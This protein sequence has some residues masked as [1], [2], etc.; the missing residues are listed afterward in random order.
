MIARRDF[1]TLLGGAAAAWP[2]AARGQQTLPMVAFVNGGESA[3]TRSAEF[4][5]GLK[6]AGYLEGQNVTVEYHWINGQYDRLPALMIDLVRRR[7]RVIATPGSTPATRAAKAAT[8]TI[9]IVFA[10][11]GD[12]VKLGLVGSFPQPGGN[13][14][15]ISFFSV[16][17]IP[18]RLELL[19]ELV[20]KAVRIAVLG[21]AAGPDGADPVSR[22]M[23][24]AAQALGLRLMPVTARTSHEIDAAFTALVHD[25]A[26]ALFVQPDPFLGS[27]R[28]QLVALAARH[29]IPAVYSNRSPVEAGGLMSYGTDTDE[30]NRQVGVYVGRILSGTKP[31]DLPVVQSTKFDLAINLKT[32]KELGVTVPQTL[33]VAADEVI[34]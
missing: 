15:G 7:V 30:W 9:P 10:V 28:D 2:V 31:A 12:P 34:E 33:L 8:T 5:K 23:A 16:E 11:A 29:R 24:K 19:H 32:A 27:R 22:E 17:V 21:N 14:T 3:P 1:F 18:K 26:D 6:E 25:Q 20:P 13:A 4:Q